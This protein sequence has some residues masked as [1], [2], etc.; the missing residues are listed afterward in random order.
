MNRIITITGL[1]KPAEI[2]GVSAP[3][4]GID[5]GPAALVAPMAIF[6]GHFIRAGR[7]EE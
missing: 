7:G 2:G 1:L 3:V 4:V 6:L 5:S